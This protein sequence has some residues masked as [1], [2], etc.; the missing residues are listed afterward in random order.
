MPQINPRYEAILII[1]PNYRLSLTKDTRKAI[2]SNDMRIM[3]I[4]HIQ[5]NKY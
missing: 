2:K 3:V 1:N 4:H 5:T